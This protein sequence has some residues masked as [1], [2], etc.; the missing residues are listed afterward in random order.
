MRATVG[1]HPRLLR[2]Q[3]GGELGE[4][5][6]KRSL[7][8]PELLEMLPTTLGEAGQ[9]I[10]LLT[11]H[12]LGTVGEGLLSLGQVAPLPFQ[13]VPNALQGVGFLGQLPTSLF[14]CF[15][16]GLEPSPGCVEQTPCIRY[17]ALQSV[18]RHVGIDGCVRRIKLLETRDICRLVQQLIY[19]LLICGR[20]YRWRDW[21][22]GSRRTVHALASRHQKL[23]LPT[24]AL[25]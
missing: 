2:N 9:G 15:A 17:I 19:V 25:L 22:C 18:D 12:L 14:E 7:L 8:A 3:L 1:I 13:G 5:V 16:F 4:T 11:R 20:G 24:P 10:L 23:L 6:L 21:G